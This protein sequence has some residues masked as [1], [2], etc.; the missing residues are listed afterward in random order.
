MP[1]KD[2]FRKASEDY[3]EFI[4]KTRN[5]NTHRTYQKSL[6]HVH[7]AIKGSGV[8]TYI[9]RWRVED[10]MDVMSQMGHLLPST[11]RL[12]LTVLRQM[13]LHAGLTVLDQAI[14]KG[15]IRMPKRSRVNVRW[16]G[17]EDIALFLVSARD[18]VDYVIVT[19][20]SELG[21]RRTEISSLRVT[22]IRGDVIIVRGKGENYV[23]LPLTQ[24]VW[25]TL[26]RW[27][28]LRQNLIRKALRRVPGQDVPEELLI[29]ERGG[30]LR[31]YSP[32]T[33]QGRL[34]RLGKRVG[35]PLCPHDLRRSCGREVYLATR[36]LV[37][38]NRLLRHED[39]NQTR[40]YIGA[41]LEDAR[42]AMTARERKR[43]SIAPKIP[44]PVYVGRK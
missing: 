42:A 10:V 30:H 37:A 3:L 43:A 22:D 5:S 29:H 8:T 20:A 16:Y 40:S 39:L 14:R 25:T 12:R 24:N 17:E 38:V 27:T 13:L 32:R 36:D 4:R 11:R 1:R 44:E 26:E 2:A 33:I 19:L 28:F 41:D 21:L 15:I 35:K 18:D 7:K 9:S 31:P 6:E 23:P 34:S